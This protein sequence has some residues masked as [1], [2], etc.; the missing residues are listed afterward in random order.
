MAARSPLMT[1]PVAVKLHPG[2]SDLQQVGVSSVHKSFAII[3]G[4]AS[5]LPPEYPNR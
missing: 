3:H 5:S 2:L 4:R 1:Y